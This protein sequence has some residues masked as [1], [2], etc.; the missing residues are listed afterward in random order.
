[1]IRD[2]L[3][4]VHADPL[5]LV[6]PLDDDFVCLIR[7]FQYLE[8]SVGFV[9]QLVTFYCST[10]QLKEDALAYL[11]LASTSQSSVKTCL[12]SPLGLLQD[13]GRLLQPYLPAVDEVLLVGLAPVL[14]ISF[15]SVR[16]RDLRRRT[17]KH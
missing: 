15:S 1:M 8:W 16:E 7:Q 4:A 17:G 11:Q 14:G 10:V 13:L 12:Y 2:T 6:L 5:G 3:N 9:P